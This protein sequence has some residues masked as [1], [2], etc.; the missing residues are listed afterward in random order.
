MDYSVIIRGKRLEENSPMRR[1]THDHYY[2]EAEDHG[3]LYSPRVSVTRGKI[4]ARN[5]KILFLDEK[6]WEPFP[7]NKT[8]GKFFFAK[9]WDKNKW[10]VIEFLAS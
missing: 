6:I 1:I 8:M 5:S 9:R 10:T 2:F 4:F 7:S 3:T